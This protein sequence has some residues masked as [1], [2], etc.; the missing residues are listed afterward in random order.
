MSD[1]PSCGKMQIWNGTVRTVVFLPFGNVIED[2]SRC[3]CSCRCWFCGCG[4]V[5]VVWLLCC[6]GDF[7]IKDCSTNCL[8]RSWAQRV[9]NLGCGP[10]GGD[11]F[12]FVKDWPTQTVI[13]STYRPVKLIKDWKNWSAG[14]GGCCRGGS[15]VAFGMRVFG[16]RLQGPT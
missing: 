3:C 14:A 2:C 13:G 8:T 10:G 11:G 1:D 15:H 9:A 12:L 16:P 7:G 4:V 5:V 6:C